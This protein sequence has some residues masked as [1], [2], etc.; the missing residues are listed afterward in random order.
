MDIDN[1]NITTS[2][3]GTDN[4]A[5][6]DLQNLEGTALLGINDRAS[7]TAAATIAV[8]HSETS[9][10]TFS[11]IPTAALY[12]PSTGVAA[13]FTALSTSASEQFLGLHLQLLKR[14]VRVE[15]TGTDIDHNVAVV[16]VGGKQ[17][18]GG[19]G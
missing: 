16:L 17:Y 9:G 10:G 19:I 7:G 11:A 6:F 5:E 13:T 15:F 3:A 8:T 1:Q 4:S 14:F 12:T 18:S 2:G